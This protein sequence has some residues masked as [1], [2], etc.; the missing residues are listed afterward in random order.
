MVLGIGICLLITSIH[1]PLSPSPCPVN[2]LCILHPSLCPSLSLVNLSPFYNVV[3]TS[4][5]HPLLFTLLCL[6]RPFLFIS[7]SP[8]LNLFH[9]SLSSFYLVSASSFK[10]S[11]PSLV[12]F[13]L[14]SLFLSPPHS[15]VH[16]PLVPFSPLHPHFPLHP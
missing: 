4:L 8:S 11:S 5:L 9:S 7:S 3:S 14:S 10:N 13:I 16:F 2:I 6:L 15:S 1:L 12:V